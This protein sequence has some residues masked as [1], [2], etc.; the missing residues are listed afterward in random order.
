MQDR[1]VE[2]FRSASGFPA[3]SRC[4]DGH[5]PGNPIVPGAVILAWLAARLAATGR[6][7][8][9]VERMKFQRVL[10]PG[11]PFEVRLTSDAAGGATEGA[12]AGR[13]DFRDASGV[14]ATARVAF[15]PGNG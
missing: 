6:A 1:P 3:D 14:F 4:L 2:T 5:F 8:A 13:A 11:V 15:C 9:R 7:L 10:L 12:K